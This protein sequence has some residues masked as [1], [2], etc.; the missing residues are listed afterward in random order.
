VTQRPRSEHTHSAGS[1]WLSDEFDD[2]ATFSRH[3]DNQMKAHALVKSIA[4]LLLGL[5]SGI[6]MCSTGALAGPYCPQRGPNCHCVEKPRTICVEQLRI[7]NPLYVHVKVYIWTSFWQVRQPGMGQQEGKDGAQIYVKRSKDSNITTLSAQQCTENDIRGAQCDGWIVFNLPEPSVAQ[8]QAC[9]EYA[10]EAVAIYQQSKKVP[11][12]FNDGRWSSDRRAHYNWCANLSDADRGFMQSESDARQ[13]GL[14][15]CK[16]KVA[17]KNAPPPPPKNYTGTWAVDLSGVPYTFVLTQQG[18]A[19][20]GQ[21]VNAD[22]QRNGTLQGSVEADG[23]AQFSYVQP[24]LNTGGHGGF[25]L[26]G[27]VDKLGG[28]FFFN[29]EQAV[30]LLDGTRK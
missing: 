7:N 25:W 3:K 5:V 4:A 20:S 9:E 28:R 19:I 18:P 21:M 24:Q 29:G 10:D 13:Q 8:L 1:S 14:N 30:R 27:T 22:P 6:A 17:A 2:P 12:G 23:R 11:C 16:A 26:E 15:D